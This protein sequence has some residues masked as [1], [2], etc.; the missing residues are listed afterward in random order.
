MPEPQYKHLEF[1][2]QRLIDLAREV[3]NHEELQLLLSKH[4]DG[5]LELRL[6]EIA[7]YCE[8]V[9]E[10]DYTPEDLHRLAE[11]LK[12]KLIAKRIRFIL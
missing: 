9:V 2:D 3:Q 8:V 10:G 7:C 12:N 5:E 1:F 11:I 6:L 4:P